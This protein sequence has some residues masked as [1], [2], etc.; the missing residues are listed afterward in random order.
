MKTNDDVKCDDDVSNFMKQYVIDLFDESKRIEAERKIEFGELIRSGDGRRKF[1][2]EVDHFRFH[3]Q[4]VN[5]L[6]Y[7]KLTFSFALVLFECH[8]N[9]DFIP[10]KTLMQ[11]SFTFFTPHLPTYT[12]AAPLTFEL[13]FDSIREYFRDDFQPLNSPERFKWFR[14]KSKS[15]EP[16]PIKQKTRMYLYESLHNQSIWRSARFW[17]AAFYHAISSELDADHTEDQL[18]N[19]T[20]S[21][22]VVFL[23]NMKYFGIG[24]ITRMRFLHKHVAIAS[25]DRDSYVILRDEMLK[26]V[27]ENF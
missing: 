24:K 25:L 13:D 18:R 4:Q 1:A 14:K 26:P 10:S 6:T 12:P 15:T 23:N 3:N 19:L 16:R 20:F 9:D 22:L 5:E 17:S 11:M 8:Q 2:L 27:D 7:R 21:H